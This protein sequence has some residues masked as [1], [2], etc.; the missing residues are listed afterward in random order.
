MIRHGMAL[1]F[2]LLASSAAIVFLGGRDLHTPC[3]E[4]ERFPPDENPQFFPTGVFGSDRPLMARWCSW[5]LR[6]MGER[7]LPESIDQEHTKAYRVLVLA[8]YSSPVAVR[9]SVKLDGT[10]TLVAKVGK[11]ETNPEVLVVDN[12]LAASR[13]QAG[14][15]LD[16]LTQSDFWSAP[17]IEPWA[18][19]HVIMGGTDWLLEG[20]EEGRYHVAVR[21]APRPFSYKDAAVFL[22]VRLA[23]IDLRALP[24][25]PA[26]R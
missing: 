3:R 22:V 17:T 24:T 7:P 20:A 9:L 19:G 8:P 1:Q 5:N 18:R 11:T 4:N 13:A 16:L 6:S 10:G 12:T 25:Q 26:V 23:K 14:T 15:F 21:T 2:S